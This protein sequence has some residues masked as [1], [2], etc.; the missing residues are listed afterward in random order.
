MARCPDDSLGCGTTGVSGVGSYSLP[1]PGTAGGG[2]G[3]F[4][5]QA[6]LP[7]VTSLQPNSR[8]RV[9]DVTVGNVTKVEMQGLA[10]AADHDTR[11]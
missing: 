3:S 9:G 11:R 1:L 4:T 10:C 8:V 5:I 7:N 6:Q 2:P